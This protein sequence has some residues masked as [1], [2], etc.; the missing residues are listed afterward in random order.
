MALRSVLVLAGRESL[1]AP[2]Y[3]YRQE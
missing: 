2:P 1:L 3:R